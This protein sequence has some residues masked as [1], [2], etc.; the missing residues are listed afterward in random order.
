MALITERA[1]GRNSFTSVRELKRQIELFVE[2]HNADTPPFKRVA[3]AESIL[4]TVEKIAMYFCDGTQA[5]LENSASVAPTDQG[6][7]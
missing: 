3:T 6:L 7:P 5:E 2:R 1:T 4:Q